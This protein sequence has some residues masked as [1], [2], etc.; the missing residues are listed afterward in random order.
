MIELYVFWFRV[1][2]DRR[3][4]CINVAVEEQRKY[5]SSDFKN[6]SPEILQQ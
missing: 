4:G 2:D 5:S 6:V 3:H 1:Y